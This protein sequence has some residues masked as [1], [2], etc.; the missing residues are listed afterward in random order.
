M[1]VVFHN[2]IEHTIPVA[3]NGKTADGWYKLGSIEVSL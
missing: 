1:G 3:N 2:S